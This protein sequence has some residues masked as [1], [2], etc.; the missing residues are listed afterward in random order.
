[1]NEQHLAIRV[2]ADNPNHHLWNNHGTWFI[3]YTV[4]PDRL[5][6]ARVRRSLRTKSLKTA[7]QRRDAVLGSRVALLPTR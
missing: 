4:H 1:M 3:H 7:L 2:T 6:A 5:T